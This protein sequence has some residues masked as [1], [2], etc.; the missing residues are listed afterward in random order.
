MPVVFKSI[1]VGDKKLLFLLFVL[2]AFVK[3]LPRVRGQ[4]G[5]GFKSEG[6]IRVHPSAPQLRSHIEK[7]R[8]SII[9]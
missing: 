5:N 2:E 3:C 9:N 8:I 1:I 7:G 4:L 6:G